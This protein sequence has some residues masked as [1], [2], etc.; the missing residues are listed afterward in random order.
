MCMFLI[1]SPAECLS[2]RQSVRPSVCLREYIWVL[3]VDPPLWQYGRCLFTVN[4][5]SLICVSFESIYF[6]GVCAAATAINTTTTTTTDLYWRRLRRHLRSTVLPS[7]SWYSAASSSS[8]S[9]WSWCWWWCSR[10]RIQIYYEHCVCST[11]SKRFVFKQ[12]TSN[13]KSKWQ[14]EVSNT[15]SNVNQRN[16]QIKTEYVLNENFL[17]KETYW[18]RKNKIHYLE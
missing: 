7:T 18:R 13:S 8:T 5:I 15:I 6:V 17:R 12:S 14:E 10:Q 9:C 16:V 4:A 1:L 2:F 11:I 3:S